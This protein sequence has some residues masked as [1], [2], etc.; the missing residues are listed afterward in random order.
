MESPS[1]GSMNVVCSGI[2]Y[3][4]NMGTQGVHDIYAHTIRPSVPQSSIAIAISAKSLLLPLA[5]YP[6]SSYP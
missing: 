2:Y 3:G 4:Y 1:E 6:V 5:I